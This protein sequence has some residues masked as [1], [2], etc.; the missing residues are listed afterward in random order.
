MVSTNSQFT[1]VCATAM[2]RRGARGNLSLM[3]WTCVLASAALISCII[4]TSRAWELPPG[5][6]PVPAERVIIQYRS[7]SFQLL[8]RSLLTKVLP[9]S[10]ELPTTNRALSGFWFEVQTPEAEV[11][12]RRIM[13]DPI[14]L[15]TEVP[16]P[17]RAL[18]PERQEV[19]PAEAVFTLLIPHIPGSNNLV[20]FSSPLGRM[21]KSQAAQKIARIA[22]PEQSK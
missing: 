8:S 3:R 19:V 1:P 4:A 7:G 10:D 13:I 14:T 18:Q 15:Y 21:G 16:D 9:P 22:L 6:G 5:T 17:A 12:Y 11:K 2:N 20:L